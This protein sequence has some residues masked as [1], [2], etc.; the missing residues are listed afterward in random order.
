M[1]VAHK[2][3]PTDLFGISAVPDPILAGVISD[4]LATC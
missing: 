2:L 4:E 1:T 3:G